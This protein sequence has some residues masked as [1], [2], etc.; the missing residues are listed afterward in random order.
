MKGKRQS[1]E[2]GAR[3]ATLDEALEDLHILRRY[4]AMSDTPEARADLK[5]QERKVARLR[6]YVRRDKVSRT[7]AIA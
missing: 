6:R 3:M 1:D 5:Q 2:V 4:A 7:L